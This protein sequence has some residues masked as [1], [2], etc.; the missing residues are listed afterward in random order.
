MRNCIRFFLK[1]RII[2]VIIQQRFQMSMGMNNDM[3]T[4]FSII[5]DVGNIRRLEGNIGG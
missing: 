4:V 5:E 2:Y 1:V 3:I